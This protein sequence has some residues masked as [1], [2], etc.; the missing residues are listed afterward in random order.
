[1]IAAVIVAFVIGVA[2]LAIVGLRVCIVA[3]DQ[4]RDD[5]EHRRV[6]EHVAAA[7][8]QLRRLHRDARRAMHDAVV[9]VDSD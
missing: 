6:N 2:A 3:R 1:M 5:L 8:M 7:R 4:I 9:D